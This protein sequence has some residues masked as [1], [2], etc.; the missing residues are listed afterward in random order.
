MLSNQTVTKV[1]AERAANI[2]TPGLYDGILPAMIPI[3]IVTGAYYV[4]K[5]YYKPKPESGGGGRANPKDV[6]PKTKITFFKDINQTVLTVDG[7]IITIVGGFLI[8][9]GPKHFLIIYGFVILI[10]SIVSAFFAH[11]A[12]STG[13]TEETSDTLKIDSSSSKD[14]FVSSHFAFW[15]FVLGLLIII[16]GIL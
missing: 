16:G 9:A 6:N 12:I 3:V 5:A 7:L 8:A 10:A 15:Y 1:M 14:F 11:S 4:L 2:A 13:I